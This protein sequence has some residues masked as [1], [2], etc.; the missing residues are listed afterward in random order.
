MSE[1]SS[2]VDSRRSFVKK[3]AVT[4]G[5]AVGAY[6]AVKAVR[7]E[8]PTPHGTF[9]PLYE[10]HERGIVAE[11][12]PEDATALF[13]EIVYKNG[14]F[15]EAAEDVLFGSNDTI[16]GRNTKRVRIFPD[17]VLEKLQKHD[18]PVILGDVDIPS[19][20][21]QFLL[22]IGQ[23][24]L[25]GLTLI[26][27]KSVRK[28]NHMPAKMLSRRDF[29]KKTGYA[30]GTWAVAPF[31][32]PGIGE[33][34]HLTNQSESVERILR[35]FGGMASSLHPE[36][37]YLFFRNA[38]MA[39]KMLYLASYQKEQQGI[40][41]KIA[42]QVG[43]AHSGIEDFLLAGKSFCQKAILAYP[44]RFLD[45]VVADNGGVDDFCAMRII[46]M[47]KDFTVDNPRQEDITEMRL[48]DNILRDA[49][50]DKLLT[51]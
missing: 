18:I 11:D 29:V 50:V 16:N 31:S 1:T 25:G 19:F 2:E 8:I 46:A 51:E 13:R 4:A 37:T 44:R 27:A 24:I 21:K 22:G 14:P 23:Y 28:E 35:R 10:R 32:G 42:F 49:L 43:N 41:P 36:L 33:V 34:L 12:I 6:E 45:V 26:S 3:A 39:D 20:D 7:N 5:A 48:Q 40:S 9:V 38:V 30:V 17:I 47:T 15:R